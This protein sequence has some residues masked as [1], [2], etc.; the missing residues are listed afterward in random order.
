MEES[1]HSFMIE[2][3]EISKSSPPED[4]NNVVYIIF[5]MVGVGMILPWNVVIES[6]GEKFKPIVFLQT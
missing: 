4:T 1:K 5:M 6:L 3:Q 2:D